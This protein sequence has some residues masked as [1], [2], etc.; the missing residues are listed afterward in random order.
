MRRGV[1]ACLWAAICHRRSP[2]H[3]SRFGQRA[4]V[5]AISGTKLSLHT[6]FHRMSG[7]KLSLLAQNGPIWC[8]LR[9]QGE[10]YTV[11]TTKK[12][13]RENFV[14]NARQRSS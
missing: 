5:H 11:L 14:P 10:F 3:T 7:T 8:I 4:P 12:P 2:G 13:S 6:R 1:L 9:M